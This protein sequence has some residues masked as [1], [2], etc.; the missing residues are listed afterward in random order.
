MKSLPP[1]LSSGQSWWLQIQSAE[2]DYRSYQIFW[3][4]VGLE[5]G[6]LSHMSTTK[7]PLGKKSSG[8]GLEENREYGR[9]NPQRW[10]RN[11]LYQQ[12]LVLSWP[13]RG[14]RS[15]GIVRSRTKATEFSF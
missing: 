15:V 13:T 12:Y 10:Q 9:R 7:E 8:S 1:P 5:L 14:G 11:T 3:E 4:F 6:P 2:F